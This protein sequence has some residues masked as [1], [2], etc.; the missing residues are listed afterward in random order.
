MTTPG[1]SDNLD[2]TIDPSLLELNGTTYR[3]DS[4]SAAAKRSAYHTALGMKRAELRASSSNATTHEQTFSTFSADGSPNGAINRVDDFTNNRIPS[5]YS[6]Q[7]G[8]QGPSSEG[9]LMHSNGAGDAS[10][11]RFDFV[12]NDGSAP[13]TQIK[14]TMRGAPNNGKNSYACL[15]EARCAENNDI[16]NQLHCDEADIVEYY[17]YP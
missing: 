11:L 1:P 5:G 3:D 4:Y 12:F 16:N 6:P 9:W 2:P 13:Y 17:G 8:T 14:V 7:G 15:R 10:R